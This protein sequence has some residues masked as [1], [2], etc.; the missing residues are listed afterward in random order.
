[1]AIDFSELKE[2]IQT[3]DPEDTA[4]VGVLTRAE[5]ALNRLIRG[6]RSPLPDRRPGGYKQKFKIYGQRDGN[7][8]V[9]NVHLTTGEYK[10]GT[11]GEIFIDLDLNED[12]T[13]KGMVKSCCVAVS[14]G[15]QY[16]VPLECY[17]EQYLFTNFDPGGP[18]QAHDRIKMCSSIM[19]AVF[20]DLAITYLGRTELGQV[21]PDA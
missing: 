15:L 10:D 3:N 18:V 1:M 2:W 4:P 6:E 13:L 8:V 7:P 11:L 21:N 9:V 16:G 5:E 14:L 17:V 20:R 12:V 19:D